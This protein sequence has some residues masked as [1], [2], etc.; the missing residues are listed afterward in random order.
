VRRT[1]RAITVFILL[2]VIVFLT[3]LGVL[4]VSAAS[5]KYSISKASLLE[6]PDLVEVLLSRRLDLELCLD[7]EG[8]GL[9][10]VP[11]RSLSGQLYLEDKYVGSIRSREPFQIPASGTRTIYIILH[12]D[13]S[14]ISLSDIQYIINSISSHNGEVKISFD[15][16]IEPVILFFPIV[17]P[18]SYQF[19][20]LTSSNAPKI[21]SLS[22]HP[23]S[24]TLGETAEFHVTVRNVFRATPIDGVLDVIVKEDV[25]GGFDVDANIYHFSVHLLPGESKT[26]S[27]SFKPYKRNITRGFFLKVQW[28]SS[29]LAEQENTYPPRL[30][31]ASGVLSLVETYW[32]VDGLRVT[33][34]K[35]GEEVVAHIILKASNAPVEGTVRIKIRKDLV[36]RPDEDIKISSFT[37][38]LRKDELRE[39]T[40]TFT[41]SEPSGTSLRGYFI[42]IE[43]EISWTMPDAYPPRLTVSK[44]GIPSVVSAWWT[45]S[46]GTVTEVKNGET[47]QAHVCIRALGGD[48]QGAITIRVRKDLVSLLDEDYEIQT[49]TLSLK[50]NEQ[51]ELTVVFIASEVTSPFF[52]GYFI[53]VD[54]VT[55]GIS[56]TM[57]NSYPPRLKVSEA[58]IGGIPLL[59]KAWWTVDNQVVTE[60]KQGQTVKA[61]VLVKAIDGNLKGILTIRIRKDLALLPD[62]D[63][64]VESF[65]I[66]VPKGQTV[67]LTVTFLAS[68]KSSFS[69]RGYFIQVDFNSWE[70]SWTMESSYPPRLKIT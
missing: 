68:E 21:S 50:E 42:E 23:T 8:H 35:V 47:V 46:A 69:F 49:Y 41:P 6:I 61:H 39:Y 7:I 38:S 12:L 53:Q 22:W 36:L 31:V 66:N 37:I 52:R 17:I 16:Q 43:G 11:V 67:E 29:I 54:F 51:T 3:Y 14:S 55:W 64:E 58:P 2:I 48:L 19:Y 32:T 9:L 33:K 70:T 62:E 1:T 13:L 25:I 26:F 24:I 4:Y 65:S 15:G 59:Q 44:D 20:T 30:S 28:G 18:V 5:A 63:Y 56:W 60:A 40:L 10:S 57:E 27:G 34:C 45:T